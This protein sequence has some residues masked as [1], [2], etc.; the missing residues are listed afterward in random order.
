MNRYSAYYSTEVRLILL[1]KYN[2]KSLHEVDSFS[3]ADLSLT[4]NDSRNMI[5]SLAALQLLSIKG[6][7]S[8]N[9]PGTANKYK[10]QQKGK[11]FV[12]TTMNGLSIFSFI[13]NLVSYYLPRIRYFKGFPYSSINT[14]GNFSYTFKDL[15]VFP[16]L[17]EELEIFYKLSNLELNLIMS[18]K[19][20]ANPAFFYSLLGLPF[21]T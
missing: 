10:N 21:L 19:M 4:V 9:N 6:L 16:E 11:L 5:S 15:M 7:I 18:R 12:K 1:T 3:K 14:F 17:E 13:E 8:F 20:K 2:Y